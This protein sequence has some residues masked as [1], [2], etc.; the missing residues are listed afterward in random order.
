MI[1]NAPLNIDVINRTMIVNNLRREK[2]N[3]FY[4]CRFDVIQFL[5]KLALASKHIL[6]QVIET[7][8]KKKRWARN[9]I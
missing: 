7:K 6:F 4:Y 9:W 3:M 2:K 1:N 5:S 8:K